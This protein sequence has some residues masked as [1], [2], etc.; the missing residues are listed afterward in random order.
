MIPSYR[1]IVGIDNC[2]SNVIFKYICIIYYLLWVKEIIRVNEDNIL[3]ELNDIIDNA[4][5]FEHDNE[6]TMYL[7]IIL[8]FIHKFD[9]TKI[10]NY[11]QKIINLI[12]KSEQRLDPV[13]TYF[14][15]E[16][17]LTFIIK[18]YEYQRNIFLYPEIKYIFY[19]LYMYIDTKLKK[20]E[21][22]DE[23]K[24]KI[25]L[26]RKKACRELLTSFQFSK[27]INSDDYNLMNGEQF[28]LL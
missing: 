16:I 2:Q 18:C 26:S 15:I 4:V 13:Y 19:K 23:H 7:K 20:R 5:S 25:Y 22:I 6:L 12:K 10:R 14:L 17:V 9:V 24:R 28:D 21:K 8:H 11:F 1:K 27:L 3:S